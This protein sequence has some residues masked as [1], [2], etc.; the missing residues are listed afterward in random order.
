MLKILLCVRRTCLRGWGC[1]VAGSTPEILGI[2]SI[3]CF[4]ILV[5]CA[6]VYWFGEAGG[7][8]RHG[9]HWVFLFTFPLW[10]AWFGYCCVSVV[11]HKSAAWR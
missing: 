8:A 1:E 10:L 3:V 2:G 7:K 11:M 6:P 5:L 9:V 4:A